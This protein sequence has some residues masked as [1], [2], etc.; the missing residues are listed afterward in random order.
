MEE[1]AAGGLGCFLLAGVHPRNIPP[2]LRPEAVRDLVLP[3]L[4]HSLCVGVGEIGLET[5]SPREEEIF[6]AHLELGLEVAQRGKVF[7]VHTPRGGKKDRIA[8]VRQILGG[9]PGLAERTV[10]DHCAPETAG[11]VLAGG[12]GR[13]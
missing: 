6:A 11:N 12:T 2:D 7:G 8:Q 3:R 9:Y 1:L 13:E 10:V 4:D 5:G